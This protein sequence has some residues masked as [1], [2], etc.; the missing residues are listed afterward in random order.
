M[1]LPETLPGQL[2]A[3]FTRG[4]TSSP[5][6]TWYGTDGERTELSGRVLA[7]WVTKAANLLVEEADAEPGTTV[8]LDLPVHWRA[9]VW[10]LASWTCGARVVLPSAEDVLEDEEGPDVVVTHR[11]GEAPGEDAAEL[12]LA[13]ALP[14]LAM[15][16]DGEEL[17]SG[18]VDAAAELMSFGDH[19]GYVSEPED[20]D[21]A[22]VGDEV[23]A[24]FADLRGWAGGAAEDELD[25]VEDLD[26]L[27]EDDDE[28]AGLGDDDLDALDDLDDLEDD[29]E[30]TAARVLLCPDTLEE[31]LEHA[32]AVWHAG[33]SLVLVEPGT[34]AETM[35]RIASEERVQERW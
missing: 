3:T 12:V 25:D 14:A 22:L 24:T 11:P 31:L 35:D 4:D 27:V 30:P 15:E 34:R 18:V 19:L 5:R 10:A 26:D 29:D 33:G 28:D 7:N 13:V 20:D 1:S 23:E 32:L 17:P 16:W 9:A 2:L 8:V 21:V 6:L